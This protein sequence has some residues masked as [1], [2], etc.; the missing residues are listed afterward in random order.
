M[1]AFHYFEFRPAESRFG[2]IAH[3]IECAE[4]M[5]DGL[6]NELPVAHARG[7]ID[8]W[9]NAAHAIIDLIG[10][11][12][13]LERNPSLPVQRELEQM[14]SWRLARENRLLL[15]PQEW[16]AE[17]RLQRALAHAPEINEGPHDEEEDVSPDPEEDFGS[18]DADEAPAIEP[19]PVPAPNFLQRLIRRMKP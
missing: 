18:S 6:L 13:P 15:V 10:D 17:E 16:I 11:G 9:R 12:E 1:S 3:D 8:L 14:R 4:K 2:D 5:F 19:A 7:R